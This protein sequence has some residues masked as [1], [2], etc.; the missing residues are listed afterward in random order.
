MEPTVPAVCENKVSA[1]HVPQNHT[2]P[3]ST[4]EYKQ[5]NYWPPL[6]SI[7]TSVLYLS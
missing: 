7:I 1:S 3:D 5:V 4:E 6:E 2:W